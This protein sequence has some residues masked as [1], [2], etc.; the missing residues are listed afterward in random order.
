MPSTAGR[1]VATH[2]TSSEQRHVTI[3]QSECWS[4]RLRSMPMSR[5]MCGLTSRS[6][7]KLKCQIRPLMIVRRLAPSAHKLKAESEPYRG[8]GNTV[9]Y[10][11]V[12]GS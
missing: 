10:I 11:A 7:N 4:L 2:I 9:C 6:F 3:S 1:C 12:T 5:R 8:R